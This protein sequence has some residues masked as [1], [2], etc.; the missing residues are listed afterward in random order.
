MIVGIQLEVIY[1][2]RVLQLKVEILYDLDGFERP[3][4]GL[5]LSKPTRLDRFRVGSSLTTETELSVP[6]SG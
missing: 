6:M 3:L 4:F 5:R 1:A 2:L